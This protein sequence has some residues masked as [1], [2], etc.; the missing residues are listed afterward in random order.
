[1]NRVLRTFAVVLAMGPMAALAQA[2]APMALPPGV[3]AGERDIALATAGAYTLDEMHTAVIVRVSHIGYSQSVFRFDRAKG[4]LTWDP[5]AIEKSKLS[6]SVETAS[7]TTN[8]KGFAEELAGENFLKSKAF[9][10]ATFVSTAFKPVDKTRGKVEGQFTLMGK[11]KPVTFDVELG[12]AGK[13]FDNKP[14][15]GV[16]AVATINPQDYGLP[17]LFTDPIQIQID[18]EFEKNP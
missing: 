14:R 6:A 10:E 17:S 11:T 9:P 8:V 15:I 12:G 5:A 13:G 4:S 1:M 18:T 3:F 16:H 2:P 7:I